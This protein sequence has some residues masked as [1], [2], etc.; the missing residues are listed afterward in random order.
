V[1]RPA[2]EFIRYI[3]TRPAPAM[4]GFSGRTVCAHGLSRESRPTALPVFGLPGGFNANYAESLA[5]SS[6]TESLPAVPVAFQDDKQN[7]LGHQTESQNH[8][9]EPVGL[10][11]SEVRGQV[12]PRSGADDNAK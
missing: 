10:V 7:H 5:L 11:D 1:V 3:I 2:D 6:S 4:Q 9:S 8:H 12:P